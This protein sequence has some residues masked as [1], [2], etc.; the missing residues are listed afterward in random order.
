M[1]APSISKLPPFEETRE[2]TLSDVVRV[3]LIRWKLMLAI[4]VVV[5]IGTLAWSW[6]AALYRGEGVLQTPTVSLADY[7]RY[8]I[9]LLDGG[10]FIA[11]LG[12]RREFTPDDIALVRSKLPSADGVS[13]WV[14]PAFGFIKGDVKDLPDVAK[15][16]NQF[17]GAEVQVEARSADLARKLAQAVGDYV[18]DAMIRGRV[19]DF[20]GTNL[21]DARIALGKLENEALQNKFLLAQQEKR[22]ADMRDIN[23]RYPEASRENSRQVVSL[24]K[25]GARYF[26]PVAQVVGV[27]SYIAE[28]NET[29][30]KLNHDRERI[31]ADLMFLNRARKDVDERTM[32][33]QKLDMLEKA[34]SETLGVTDATK[35]AVRESFYTAKLN[36]G[37]IRY[38][39][40]DGLRFV[41]PPV[42]REPS[43]KQI[44]TITA[45]AAVAGLLLAMIVSLVL[46]WS[47]IL[48]TSKTA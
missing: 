44:F 39:A 37:Q 3:M 25:G 42:V 35:D 22:L 20:V 1:E 5:T 32:G 27:E 47:V 24:E 21:N 2:L 29:I 7:K 36:I 19:N 28:I 16:E 9:P 17:V 6:Y 12:T 43:Y 40:D 15:L 30:R 38:L 26:A 11:F 18:A 31:Q 8:S 23:R 14:R 33:R 4:V 46:A 10:A 34:F 48:R 45:A 41:S 13:P